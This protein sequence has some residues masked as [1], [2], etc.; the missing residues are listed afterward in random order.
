[1]PPG[2]T[3]HRKTTVADSLLLGT[4]SMLLGLGAVACL[5]ASLGEADDESWIVQLGFFFIIC[6]P[7][8]G[9]LNMYFSHRDERRGLRFQ[10][11]LGLALS[12][13]AVFVSI[14][15]LLLAD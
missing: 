5:L 12:A 3:A 10:A 1:M 9:L 6:T 15:P 4:F 2:A 13:L 8:L 7:P 11:R 14:S